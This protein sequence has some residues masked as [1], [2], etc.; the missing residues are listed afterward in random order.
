MC[1]CSFHQCCNNEN[2]SNCNIK[3]SCKYAISQPKAIVKE[4]MPFRADEVII[5]ILRHYRCRCCSKNKSFKN[6]WIKDNKFRSW[7]VFN[8]EEKRE[9]CEKFSY[10]CDDNLNI[11]PTLRKR[12]LLTTDRCSKIVKFY[13]SLKHR[14]EYK[15]DEERE[16]GPF[17]QTH[18]NFYFDF[19]S[20]YFGKLVVIS[21]LCRLLWN[22]FEVSISLQSF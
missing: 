16:N 22:A 6:K 3:K 9:N 20:N 14:P 7:F 8:V 5:I 19:S 10:W 11:K 2:N 17:I 18:F 1:F 4:I 12:F 13:E 21:M 15:H